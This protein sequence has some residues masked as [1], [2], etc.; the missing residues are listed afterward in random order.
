MKWWRGL[1]YTFDGKQTCPTANLWVWL[2]YCPLLSWQM[3]VLA[4]WGLP[5]LRAVRCKS[6]GD[7]DC[8]ALMVCRKEKQKVK[9]SERTAVKS[10]GTKGG[11]YRC[12]HD[13]FWVHLYIYMCVH[14]CSIYVYCHINRHAIGWRIQVADLLKKKAPKTWLPV[15]V[16][17][18]FCLEAEGA[19]FRPLSLGIPH[20]TFLALVLTFSQ[21]TFTFGFNQIFFSVNK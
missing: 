8:E 9:A 3:I 5:F 17:L 6:L 15:L 19:G 21:W 16:P 20:F 7:S 11:H 14:M 2:N 10:P 18:T 1:P 13:S 12:L 4:P